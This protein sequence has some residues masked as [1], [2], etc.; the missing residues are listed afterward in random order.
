M[1][2]REDGF[3]ATLKEMLKELGESEKLKAVW[4]AVSELARHAY[5]HNDVPL[6]TD[7][8]VPIGQEVLDKVLLQIEEEHIRP[9][10]ARIEKI[11]GTD[12]DDED[13]ENKNTKKSSDSEGPGAEAS[14]VRRKK[15]GARSLSVRPRT[16]AT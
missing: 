14:K 6:T 16:K 1:P 11:H 12:I 9:L 3:V 15:T 2:A 8:G 4:V 7:D 10:T 13:E 5:K